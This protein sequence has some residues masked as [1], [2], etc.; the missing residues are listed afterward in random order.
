M[1]FVETPIPGAYVVEFERLEDER[2]YFARTWC[3]DEFL[4]LGL[5]ASLAQCSISLNHKRATLRGM[6][7]QQA[8][9]EEAKL[10]RCTRGA[11]FDVIVD[12]RPRS[13][14][15]GTYFGIHL[16]A[17]SSVMLYVPEGVA[18]GY[19]TLADDTEVSYWISAAY[20]P[21]AQ[22]GFRWDDSEVGIRWPIRPE[23][24]SQRDAMLPNF[25]S[26]GAI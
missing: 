23:C 6:H 8:P 12:A 17:K 18:H 25:R 7:Y 1:K 22:R 26:R 11:M 24:V 20:E 21:T 13:S 16:D 15:E 5:R 4:S 3:A 10:V 14:S 19:E 2:G 9:H